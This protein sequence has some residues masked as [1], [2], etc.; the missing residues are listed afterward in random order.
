M[1]YEGGQDCKSE[2]MSRKKFH[3][4]GTGLAKVTGHLLTALTTHTI[5]SA[6]E[7]PS[8]LALLHLTFFLPPKKS[9]PK[10]VTAQRKSEEN[11]KHSRRSI[12][13]TASSTYP[14]SNQPSC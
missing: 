9:F 4:H 14:H 13:G 8:L 10:V 7:T 5:P 11:H 12:S 2:G 3:S 1:N 6:T